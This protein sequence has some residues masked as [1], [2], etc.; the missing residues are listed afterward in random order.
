MQDTE[1]SLAD[2]V[3]SEVQVTCKRYVLPCSCGTYVPSKHKPAPLLVLAMLRQNG[4]D[5]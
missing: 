5:A 1:A 4:S 3:H 2:G